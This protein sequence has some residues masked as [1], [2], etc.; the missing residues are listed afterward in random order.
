MN[1]DK[2]T[3]FWYSL[4]IGQCA[5]LLIS[6]TSNA[7]EYSR[8]SKLYDYLVARRNNCIRE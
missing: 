8:Y 3:T 2:Y 6:S 4:L 7:I 5:D 1:P